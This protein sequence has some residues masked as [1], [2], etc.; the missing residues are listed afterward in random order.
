M[1]KQILSSSTHLVK[2]VSDE[3][4]LKIG[5]KKI[6]REN[7]VR[8]L[9]VLLD[10]TLSWKTHITE[11]SK[12]LSR[13]VGLF[14]KIM[15][16]APQETLILLYHGMF[17]SPLFYGIAVWSLTRPYL[18]HSIFVIQKK[19]GRT[20]MFK[21]RN[22]HS[23]P[24]FGSL[25]IL[26]LEQVCQLQILSFVYECRNKLSPALFCNY[27]TCINDIHHIG[28]CQAKKNQLICMLNRKYNPV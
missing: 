9:G 3:I 26:K 25:Q 13:T 8:F 1:I 20:I 16:P 21:K 2:K 22:E 6:H 5:K 4:T 7:H 15:H 12:K 17:A 19:V 24:L 10:A 28:T 11:L 14:H 23:K 27:F 18:I